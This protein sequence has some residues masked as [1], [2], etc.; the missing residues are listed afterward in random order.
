ML[1]CLA[2]LSNDEVFTP[3]EIVN[4]MLDMLPQELFSD[5][6]VTFLDPACKSGV[7]LREIAKRLLVGLE[8]EIPDLQE[9]IEHIFHKQ[10]FGI[11][12]TEMTSLLSRRSVYCSKYPNGKFSIA[13]FDDA[14]GNI[15]FKKLK[16]VWRGEKCAFCGASK[17]EYDRDDAL[18]THAYELIHTGKPEEIFRMKFDVIIGNPPYQLSDG[19]QK[20]SATPIYHRFIQQAKKLSP[21]YLSMIIPARWFSGGRGL[22]SFREEMLNDN[23]VRK[24]V[25]YSDSNDCF[26]GVDIAGGICYFLW[27]RDSHGECAVENIHNGKSF[28]TTRNLNEHSIFIR[29]GEAL[30]IIEKARKEDND[31]YDSRVSSQKPFGLR[32]YV[33]PTETGD[34]KL[35]YNGGT[36]DFSRADVPSGLEWIDKWKVMMSYLTYD[37]AGRADKDGRRRIFS[38]ME[39]LPPGMVCTETYIVIDTFDNEEEAINLYNYLRTCFV[40]FLVAQTTSTQHLAKANFTFVPIQDF[41]EPWTDEKLYAKYGITEDEIAFIESMIRPMELGGGGDE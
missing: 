30:P 14:E 17:A 20:A 19:G 27:E 35:R 26:P 21:R 37:H 34:I 1:S 39:I 3:P 31:F 6:S 29:Y 13:K 9:R 8:N 4:K 12:I 40:R 15:R 2:N 24:I 41:S 25:D 23:R 38:T 11:A 36:G 5:K 22:D 32:T 28:V 18:E 33:K 10:L 7:F 16:H